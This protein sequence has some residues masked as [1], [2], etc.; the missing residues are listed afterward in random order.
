MLT[1]RLALVFAI[2]TLTALT[3][4]AAEAQAGWWPFDRWYDPF[5]WIR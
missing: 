4:G 5:D 2:V 1:R 3:I